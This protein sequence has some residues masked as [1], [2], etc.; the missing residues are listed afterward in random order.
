[1]TD[2]ITSITGLITI[3][4]SLLYII[5]NLIVI[6]VQI[7]TNPY[8]FLMC[9]FTLS[10]LYV[11]VKS[12]TQQEILIN[13]GNYYKDVGKAIYNIIHSAIPVIMGII[14]TIAVI[15]QGIMDTPPITIL[16]TGISIGNILAA[17]ILIILIIAGI[18]FTV[19]MP[20]P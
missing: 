15:I 5:F 1:M 14:Q 20:H 18:L 2:F 4:F 11:L 19:S 13:Y 12:K 16:G 10:H 17:A 9:I 7:I 6:G 3:A 8:L